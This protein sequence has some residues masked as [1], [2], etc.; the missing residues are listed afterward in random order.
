MPYLALVVG[1][2]LGAALAGL[3][4]ARRRVPAEPGGIPAGLEGCA[5][6]AAFIRDRKVVWV[7]ARCAALLG[8]D[9]ESLQGVDT[10]GWHQDDAAFEKFGRVIEG[11]SG[12]GSA[13]RGEVRLRRVDGSPFWAYLVGGPV[14]PGRPDQGVLWFLE[15]V[16]DRVEAQMDLSEVL[17]LNQKLI[18][19]SPTGIMLYRDADGACVLT[20]E[21]AARIL[22]GS[23][24]VILQQNFRRL[25]SWK[26]SGLRAAAD[27]ALATGAD[28]TVEAHF[29]SSFGKEVWIVAHLVPFT[30]RGERLL[31]LLGDDV[32]EK[33][34]ATRALRASEEKYRVV[35]ET[36]NEGLALMESTGA[37]TFGNQRLAEMG[38]Y[39][40]GEL[41]GRHYS[42][43]VPEANLPILVAKAILQRP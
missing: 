38:G 43:F 10:R 22:N 40:P 32:S 16:S 8:S 1:L 39:A 2:L 42:A 35:V 4:L 21:A 20:N 6:G 18:A 14:A 36:L 11:F 25:K 24:D 3:A 34:E 29:T 33:I 27:R 17:S 13:F 9:A 12:P 23:P 30:S 31:L 26:E 37:R 5:M 7:N 28:Q 41:L 15:D 19:A